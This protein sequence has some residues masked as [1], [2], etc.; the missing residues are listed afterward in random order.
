MKNFSLMN[1]GSITENNFI[2]VQFTR[3]MVSPGNSIDQFLAFV[4][5]S[6]VVRGLSFFK[7]NRECRLRTG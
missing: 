6:R 4:T 7:R 1:L 2:T 5:V 3:T